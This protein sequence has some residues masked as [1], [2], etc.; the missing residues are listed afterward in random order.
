MIKFDF[1][2]FDVKRVEKLIEEKVTKTASD[3]AKTVYYEIIDG[4]YPE[5]SGAYIASWNIGVGVPDYTHK[6]LP[7]VSQGTPDVSYS[8]PQMPPMFKATYGVPIYVTNS[9][10]Y[11]Y[12][13]EHYGSPLHLGPW[14][15]LHH[16]V[17]QTK[18]RF[19]MF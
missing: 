10:P 8:P 5:W 14:M 4:N 11:A 3:L 7:E 6:P 15:I 13:I 1:S 2:K 12:D 17:T 9:V 16:A 18:S 19:G